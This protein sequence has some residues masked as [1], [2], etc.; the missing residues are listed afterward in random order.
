MEIGVDYMPTAKIPVRKELARTN[1]SIKNKGLKSKTKTRVKKALA[2]VHAS[3]AVEGLKP[4]KTTV[5]L[6]RQY[7]EGKISG[8]EAIAKV[9]ARHF[10]GA[11]IH[12][13]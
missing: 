9:K 1:T 8:Q 4:S 11:I 10:V 13:D 5:I 7:L 2:N 3:M 6:G 12:N